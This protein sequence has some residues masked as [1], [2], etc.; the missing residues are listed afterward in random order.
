VRYTLGREQKSTA[1]IVADLKPAAK[2]TTSAQL[3]ACS[4]QRKY[5]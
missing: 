3:I 5:S 4:W 1:T 2:A